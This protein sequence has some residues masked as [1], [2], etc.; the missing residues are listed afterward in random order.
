MK[1]RTVGYLLLFSFFPT[2][3][4]LAQSPKTIISKETIKQFND[5]YDEAV[6]ALNNKNYPRYKELSH[7][8][9]QIAPDHPLYMYQFSKSLALCENVDE[10]LKLLAK[11]LNH[12][13][14]IVKSAAQDSSFA[15]L[16]ENQKFKELIQR[17]EKELQPVNNSVTA[18]T[19]SERDLMSEGVAY[20]AT[21]KVLYLSSIYKRKIISI[22][23]D[24]KIQNFAKEKQDGLLGVLGMEVD[25]KRRHLWVCTGWSGRNDILDIKE[26]KEIIPAI[27]K[28]N[29]DSG[30]LIKK[31]AATDT[32]KHL[33]NDLTV[34]SNGD[35]FITDTFGGKVYTVHHEQDELSSFSD[36][37]L[38]PNGITLSDDGKDLFIAH[39]LG[40]DKIDLQTGR[41]IQM[42]SPENI[43][44]VFI[45]GL[46]FYKNTLIA[47][48]G[49]TLGG[50]YQFSLSS[51][52]ERVI[53]KK[54]IEL[55]NPL[56]EFP[57]T[58]EIAGDTYFYLANA[59]FRGYNKDG[60]IFPYEK[61][62]DVY[63]LKAV[64]GNKMH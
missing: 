5:T 53:S 16:F 57:T 41:R 7:Q 54:A 47:H 56:F 20:D 11:T 28:Y 60:S 26:E 48:Q 29:I 8:L 27:L 25:E 38:Y 4:L 58:G 42:T 10:S 40:L 44:L 9:F 2:T 62:S 50:I 51:T 46:T 59:Q 6:N 32:I 1:F 24:G 3:F 18:F 43:T 34:H 12:G 17:A 19:I 52:R 31:Y 36:V 30:N 35:V 45:D 14:P 21:K 23:Q 15:I 33:F 63:V 39:Y 64:L 61:L 22:T 55:F 13:A 49:S 37:Y